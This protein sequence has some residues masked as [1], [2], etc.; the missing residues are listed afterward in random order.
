[1]ESLALGSVLVLTV[2][3]TWGMTQ[4]I[5]DLSLPISPIFPVILSNKQINMDTLGSIKL[6]KISTITKL[7]LVASKLLAGVLGGILYNLYSSLRKD[8][9][10]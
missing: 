1:M 10:P 4:Q 7:D 3:D 8:N 6:T 5:E 2:L 9:S